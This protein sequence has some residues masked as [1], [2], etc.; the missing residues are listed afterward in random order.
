[1]VDGV[2][3]SVVNVKADSKIVESFF[4]HFM[5][6][7]NHFLRR[8]AFIFCFDCDRHS[9]F[10]RAAH[11]NDVA[12][13]KSQI[14]GVNICRKIA[15]RHMTNVYRT[16]SIRQSS[17]DCISFWI[18]QFYIFMAAKIVELWLNITI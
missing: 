12:L 11:K 6:N 18:V 16:V 1:M 15:A 9:M 10:I 7:I 8:Y 5:I 17:S 14:A 4:H 13:M 3:C 2:G